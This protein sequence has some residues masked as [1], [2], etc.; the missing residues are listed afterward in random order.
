MINLPSIDFREYKDILIK[1]GIPFHLYINTK[2]SKIEGGLGPPR[3]MGDKIDLKY[4][5]FISKVKASVKKRIKTK[6]ITPGKEFKV[7]I[8]YFSVSGIYRNKNVSFKDCSEVDINSAYWHT[9]YML[10]VITKAIYNEGNKLTEKY[11]ALLKQSENPGLPK[12]ERERLINEANILKSIRLIALGSLA[13][14]TTHYYFNGKKMIQLPDIVDK[15]TQ[16]FWNQICAHVSLLMQK[17]ATEIKEDYLFYWVDAI[18]IRGEKLAKVKR[19]IKDAG[20]EFKVKKIDK[21]TFRKGE[22]IA[23]DKSFTI[24]SKRD[25]INQEI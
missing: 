13:K 19:M 9:A 18:F 12:E 15:D 23:G 22:I 25:A 24:S 6:E 10:N 2:S 17:M 5:G 16:F 1:E 8:D 3:Y 20:Y 21:I 4:M 14:K 11:H 7:K